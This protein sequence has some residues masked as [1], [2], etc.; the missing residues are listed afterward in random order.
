[1]V[2]MDG[3]RL[4]SNALN[5]LEENTGLKAT[6]VDQEHRPPDGLIYD[7]V[8]KFNKIKPEL[9]VETQTWAAHKNIGVLINKYMNLT[10]GAPGLLVADYINDNMGEKLK[11]EKINYVDTVGNAFIDIP[12]VFIYLKGNKNNKTKPIPREKTFTPNELKMI[13][14]LLTNT[15]LLNETYR[16]I[17]DR[18]N[19]ALGNVGPTFEKL[20]NIGFVK[21]QIKTKKRAFENTNELFE[22]WVDGYPALRRKYFLGQYAADDMHWWQHADDT[23]PF[24]FWFGGE[25]AGAIYT[26]L[27]RPRNAI[28]YLE[29]KD[30]HKLLQRYRFKNTTDGEYERPVVVLIERFWRNLDFETERLAPPLIA[31]ADLIET[32]DVRNREAANAIKEKHLA[33]LQ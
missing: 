33:Y 29:R 19:I 16:E 4:T 27:L 26:D 22:R 3:K 1:M 20:K 15:R 8:V 24:E 31:Y 11:E 2:N 18:A 13:F 28:V 30:H 32:G 6:V 9:I 12:P 23:A 17:A 7:F 14:A 21:E 10:K 25:I 5:V